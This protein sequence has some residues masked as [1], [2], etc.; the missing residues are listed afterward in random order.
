M[1]D[2]ISPAELSIVLTPLRNSARWG[3][4]LKWYERVNPS[5]EDVHEVLSSWWVHC[6]QPRLEGDKIVNLF[7]AGRRA[8]LIRDDSSLQEPQGEMTIYRAAA[9]DNPDLTDGASWS[10]SEDVVRRC[11]LPQRQTN[12]RRA[13]V[14]SAVIV[15]EGLRPIRA[16]R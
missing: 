15:P 1:H 16:S 14:H 3:T 10:E 5:D 6:H 4:I 2:P 9:C 7:R 11:F 12:G 8:G 13:A